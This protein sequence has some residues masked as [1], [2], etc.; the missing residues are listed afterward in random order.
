MIVKIF[1][2]NQPLVL[3][4]LPVVAAALW[5]ISFLYPAEVTVSQPM[6]LYALFSWLIGDHVIVNIAVA[7]AIVIAQAIFLNGIF[8]NNEFINRETYLPA[9]LYTIFCGAFVSQHGMHPALFANFFLLLA[10]RRVLVIYRQPNVYSQVFDAGIFIGIGSLF[11]FPTLLA[12]PFI[13]M[14][15]TIL[16]PFIWR[17][18]FI[19]VLAAVVPYLFVA[20][21]YYWQEQP[22]ALWQL[23]QRS[24]FSM[25][26]DFIG[27]TALNYTFL[28]LLLWL[29][30]VGISHVFNSMRNS[31]MRYKKVLRTFFSF[32]FA[33]LLI[34][35]LSCFNVDENYRFVLLAIP[36][37]VLYTFY[38]FKAKHQW[39]AELLF[40]SLLAIIGVGLYVEIGS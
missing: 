20:V 23:Y 24:D 29:L 8:N 7:M 3:F 34:Y 12:F 25:A 1:R 28:G 15:L 17:E 33:T 4:V 2:T 10:L 31:T 35:A 19:P 14:A 13:W 6:P 27:H 36:L 11:Y 30:L 38:F 16:R 5:A 37:S 21:Y 18:W 39:W 32:A 22:E 40:Y 9:L 26:H